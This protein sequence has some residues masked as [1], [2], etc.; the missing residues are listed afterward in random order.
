MTQ[1]N[2]ATGKARH[3]R[4]TYEDKPK[5]AHGVQPG[6]VVPG[7]PVAVGSHSYG[8]GPGVAC[9]T[10]ASPDHYAYPAPYAGAV[11]SC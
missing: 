8:S 1:K 10:A 6:Y 2:L 5:L 4:V 7:R 11:P 9:A 3:I